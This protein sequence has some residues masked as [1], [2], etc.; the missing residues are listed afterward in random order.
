V[1]FASSAGLLQ[2]RHTLATHRPLVVPAVH[3][4]SVPVHAAP[5]SCPESVPVSEPVS[6]PDSPTT[7]P[8]SEPDSSTVPVSDSEVSPC[9]AE[10]AAESP[11]F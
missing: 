10:S 1:H 4:V 6:E 8:V 9:I 7:V 11:A 2:G 5:E 3:A